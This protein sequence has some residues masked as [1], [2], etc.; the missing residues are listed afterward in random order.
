MIENTFKKLN[1]KIGLS[2][3]N[4]ALTDLVEG[5]AARPHPGVFEAVLSILILA[6]PYVCVGFGVVLIWFDFPNVITLILG[7][8]FLGLAWML[9]PRKPNL[10]H[11]SYTR[12]D[13]PELFGLLDALATHLDAP[14]VDRV[15]FSSDFNAS[16]AL[17]R[18]QRIIGIGSSFWLALTPSQKLALLSH[19]FGHLANRD[20]EKFALGYRAQEVMENFL[21]LSDDGFYYDARTNE[22]VGHSSGIVADMIQGAFRLFLELVYTLLMKLRFRASQK[23]EYLADAVS[24]RGAGPEAV[25]ALMDITLMFETSDAWRG[26]LLPQKGESGLEF[27]R[28]FANSLHSVPEDRRKSALQ[29]HD[30]E[31]LSLDSTHPPTKYRKE[32]VREL[33]A[34]REITPLEFSRWQSVET[35]LAPMF[36]ELGESLK[37]EFI[38][39]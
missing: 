18:G 37:A 14:K 7:A 1:Q 23:A 9:R 39:Y 25:T 21:F 8:A 35:E 2:I 4:A 29:K 31:L 11:P 17:I 34:N 24:L 33:P 6:V 28:R 13:L 26:V 19:E 32:F 12:S 38:N 30:A 27:A 5:R 16:A 3:Y 22:F 15:W 20:S 10:P 36:D